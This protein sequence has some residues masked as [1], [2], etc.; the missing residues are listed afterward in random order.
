MY[1]STK[2]H[3]NMDK[4]KLTEFIESRL[5]GT[6][7]YLV[8]LKITPA[9][10]ITVEIDS[11]GTADLEKCIELT[12]AIEEAFSRDEEDYELEVGTSGLMSPLKVFRQYL[13][14]IGREL[15]VLTTDGR[16]LRGE[17]IE[18]DP[19]KGIVLGVEEKVKHEGA[20]RPVIET[21]EIALPFADIKKAEYYLRF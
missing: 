16:K 15:E 11:D 13:K 7:Y 6:D 9:N 18:A 17:L 1:V 20:K 12:R 14:Y 19:E 3:R 4:Q 5:E 8:D 21:R 10:E 2:T